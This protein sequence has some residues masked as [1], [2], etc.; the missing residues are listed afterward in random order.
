MIKLQGGVHPILYA[1]F[2]EAGAIDRDAMRR[3]VE[4]CI[5]SGAPGI[6]ILG[7]ATE[8]RHL[9]H[10]QRRQIVSNCVEDIAGRIQLGVTVFADTSDLQI[11]EVRWVA[12]Q[13]ADWV[14]LQQS[15]DSTDEASL[16]AGFDK[17]LANCPL[18]AA[19][20][21]MPQFLGAGLG[22][23]SITGLAQRH[24]MMISVK[25][26][27]SATELAQ[28]ALDVGDRLQV[29]SGRGGIEIIDCMRAGA[30]GHIPAPEYADI[31]ANIWD[32]MASGDEAGARALYARILPM[33]TFVLQ[34]LE[35]LTTYGKLLFCLRHDLPYHQRQGAMPL[36]K[37]GIETLIRHAD[38]AGITTKDWSQRISINDQN[39]LRI[40]N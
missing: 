19:V 12:E 27:V 7:L 25:Q 36:S 1:L 28:L 22:V 37:F 17:V 2:D 26:E 16:V 24:P 29:M 9:T 4:I 33:A 18:P 15:A 20:Q 31:L 39:M 32:L 6:V 13:G 11:E 40:T 14:V 5:E 10:A 35:A 30:T 3:Q 8:V 38:F 34:S 21:N 23:A